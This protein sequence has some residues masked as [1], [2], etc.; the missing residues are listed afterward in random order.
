M[1]NCGHAVISK[2]SAFSVIRKHMTAMPAPV[3]QESFKAAGDEAERQGGRR[4]G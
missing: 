1:V 4:Q 3:E 2:A